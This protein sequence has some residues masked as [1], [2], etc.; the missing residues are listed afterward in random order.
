MDVQG[1][2]WEVAFPLRPEEK[3]V[4]LR[5]TMQASC[6]RRK[7]PCAGGTHRVQGEGPGGEWLREENSWD[8]MV[9]DR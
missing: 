6:A 7:R 1:N 9:G 3:E 4:A 5:G 2:V 8:L